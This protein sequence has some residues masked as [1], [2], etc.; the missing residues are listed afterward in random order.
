MSKRKALTHRQ[1]AEL[2]RIIRSIEQIR[3]D[4]TSHERRDDAK[5]QQ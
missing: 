3:F 2:N 4:A 5:E 1:K